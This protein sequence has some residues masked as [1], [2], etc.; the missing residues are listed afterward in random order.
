VNYEHNDDLEQVVKGA[1]GKP[2]EKGMQA[3]ISMFTNESI[4]NG[5]SKRMSLEVTSLVLRPKKI[6]TEF[7]F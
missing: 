3:E 4:L 6:H 7:S 1:G 2:E 5:D